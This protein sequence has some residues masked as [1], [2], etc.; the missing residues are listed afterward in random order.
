MHRQPIQELIVKFVE[1]NPDQTK[2]AERILQLVSNHEDC[3]ERTCLPGHVTGSAWVVSHDW[4]RHLLLHHRKLNK[5]LQPGGHAEGENDIAGVALR[6][7]TEES[8]LIDLQFVEAYEP[9]AL[10]DLDVH[11]IPAR[12]RSTGEL[13]DPAHEH[14]DLRFLIQCPT[15]QEPILSDESNEVRWLTEAE[16][17]SVTDEPSVL[18]LLDKA[19]HFREKMVS[20]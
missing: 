4:Q 16:V 8:G 5:W 18:R 17:R 14:H 6:E 11:Q 12:H 10:I 19:N 2:V 20:S 13:I 7:A 15:P 1:R 3:F 9:A